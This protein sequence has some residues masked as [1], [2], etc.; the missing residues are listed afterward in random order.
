M[1]KKTML[2]TGASKGIGRACLDKFKDDYNIITVHRSAGATMQGD[3]TDQVFQDTVIKTVMPDIFINN[4]G[5]LT[6]EPT[7]TLDL[8]G[9]AACKL[10]IEFHKK[11]KSGHIINISSIAANEQGNPGIEYDD[12]AYAGSKKMLSAISLM[13]HKQKNKPVKVSCLELGPTYT[14]K[15]LDRPAPEYPKTSG[16]TTNSYTPLSVDTITNTIE[17]ILN[18]SEWVNTTIFRIDTNSKQYGN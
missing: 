13:L 14:D 5:G 10:L 8:N 12:I 9:F 4:A 1:S 18:Q 17:F 6:G 11:M 15:F 7:T 3:L 16:W 2:I